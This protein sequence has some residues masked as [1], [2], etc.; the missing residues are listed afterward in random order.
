M[1]AM[2]ST[3]LLVIV[4][5]ALMSAMRVSAAVIWDDLIITGGKGGDVIWGGWGGGGFG[6]GLIIT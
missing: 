4:L 6:D 1:F 5:F 2:Y 3:V